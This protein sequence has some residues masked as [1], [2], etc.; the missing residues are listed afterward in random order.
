MKKLFI[1]VSLLLLIIAQGSGCTTLSMATYASSIAGGNYK[2]YDGSY[3][4]SL[5][6]SDKEKSYT[7][8]RKVLEKQ[9]YKSTS[10]ST[11][12][13]S[14]DNSTL[15][16]VIVSRSGSTTISAEESKGKLNIK[17][18]QTGNYNYGTEKEVKETFDEIRKLY[19]ESNGQ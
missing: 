15:E 2:S 16:Q 8:L 9:G 11:F 4:L 13:Y 17:I 3:E 7:R 10:N 14:K 5:V 18:F 6:E 19:E 1:K 12:Q